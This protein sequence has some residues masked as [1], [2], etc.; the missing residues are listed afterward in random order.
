MAGAPGSVCRSVAA[1]QA[2]LVSLKDDALT[3]AGALQRVMLTT[4]H[5]AGVARID[6][7]DNGPGISTANR[8]RLRTVILHCHPGRRHRAGL[9]HR[10]RHRGRRR[11]QPGHHAPLNRAHLLICLPAEATPT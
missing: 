9:G 3:L 11:W 5:E 8:A 4:A 6:V 7:H 1:L 2:V 10:T